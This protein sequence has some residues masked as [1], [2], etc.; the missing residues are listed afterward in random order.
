M[1][2]QRAGSVVGTLKVVVQA[3]SIDSLN[4]GKTTPSVL[5]AQGFDEEDD[6]DAPGALASAVYQ[7]LSGSIVETLEDLKAKA[8]P[9]LV[10]VRHIET[11]ASHNFQLPKK[12]LE[13]E[14]KFDA[15]ELEDS[16]RQF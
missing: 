10:D 9:Q 12:S 8:E 14:M 2:W 13:D 6:L 15:Q 11:T 1:R 3:S 16:K 5:N 7:S 4:A